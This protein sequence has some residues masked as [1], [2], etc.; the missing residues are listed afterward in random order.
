MI[1]V[2]AIILHLKQ[3]FGMIQYTILIWEPLL[4]LRKIFNIMPWSK[5]LEFHVLK[6]KT[7]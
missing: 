7:S 2:T 1:L 4:I 5:L 6:L 3:T